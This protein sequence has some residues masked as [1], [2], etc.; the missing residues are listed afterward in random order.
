[1]PNDPNTHMPPPQEDDGPP[2][3]PVEVELIAYLDGELDPAAARKMEARI[4]ADPKLRAQAES[5]RRSYGLLDFLPKPEPSSTFTSRTIDRLPAV[6][7]SPAVPLARTATPTNPAPLA[8]TAGVVVASG[9]TSVSRLAPTHPTHA[10]VSWAWVASLMLGVVA[11]LGLGYLGAAAVRGLGPTAPPVAQDTPTIEL[12][13]WKN[14]PLYAAIDD[15][16]TL[17]QLV[18]LDLFEYHHTDTP[19]LLATVPTP[20][21]NRDELIRAFRALPPERQEKIRQFE[22]SLDDLDAP[23]R[24]RLFRALETYAAWL[25]R[26]PDSDRKDI[27]SAPTPEKRL[28][29]IKEVYR[30]Q[31]VAHLPLAQR[32]QLQNLPAAERAGLI[33]QWKTEE[34][35]RRDAWRV[36]HVV[37]TAYRT[38]HPP[39]PFND[40]KLRREVI[41]FAQIAYQT[42]EPAKSRLTSLELTRLQANL[43]SVTTDA[44][45]E[46]AWLGLQL[47]EFSRPDTNRNLPRYELLPEPGPGGGKLILDFA[48]LPQAVGKHYDQRPPAHKKVAAHSGKWPDFALAVADE[49]AT[50]KKGPLLGGYS[51]GPARPEQFKPEVRVFV[52]DV[53]EKHLTSTEASHLKQIV[54]KWPEY[55]REL[56]RLAREHDLSI[57][58]VML[59]GSPKRWK[60]TY[61]TARQSGSKL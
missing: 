48:D 30:T 10:G 36:P 58:G 33:T 28:E 3:D 37:V 12:Q 60:E 24:D 25:Y 29:A 31:W 46:S 17:N 26:L 22:Q 11:A 57:P 13:A 1:M 14:L 55:P 44:G 38:G 39:W 41:E 56:I 2:P 21:P 59:P 45:P 61:N 9:S 47:Y 50:A 53:L 54:G 6:K 4:A 40:D 18:A 20:E 23:H 16:A 8:A 34:A 35:Q 43:K 19:A 32:K 7:S 52:H 42:N 49:I 51:F 5:L 15:Y 27:L